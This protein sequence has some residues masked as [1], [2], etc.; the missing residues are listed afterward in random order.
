MVSTDPEGRQLRQAPLQRAAGSHLC[1]QRAGGVCKGHVAAVELDVGGP[2]A[3]PT[4]F[5]NVV[6][7]LA[8]LWCRPISSVIGSQKYG[9]TTEQARISLQANCEKIISRTSGLSIVRALG[10][11]AMAPRASRVHYGIGICFEIFCT[12]S[13]SDGTQS[14]LLTKNTALMLQNERR[15]IQKCRGYI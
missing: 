1:R 12:S 14:G 15:L 2:L 11:I 13:H 4:V 9:A 10:G 7:E 3:L 8:C 6:E 5:H